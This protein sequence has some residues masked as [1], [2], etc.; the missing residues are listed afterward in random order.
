MHKVLAQVPEE[1]TKL[2]DER[3]QKSG[4]V[5]KSWRDGIS[6]TVKEVGETLKTGAR[7]IAADVGMSLVGC[8]GPDGCEVSEV[9]H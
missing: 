8:L 5:K 2:N 4:S 1:R 7:G 9:W 3:N 6:N